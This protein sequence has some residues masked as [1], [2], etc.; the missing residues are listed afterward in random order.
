MRAMRMLDADPATAH[1]VV[2][3]KPPGP[4]SAKRIAGLVADMQT[5]VTL[6]ILGAGTSLT[7][8]AAAVAT[9]TGRTLAEPF[10]HVHDQAWRPA[11]LAGLFC[12]GSLSIEA[13]D[14]LSAWSEEI[15]SIASLSRTPTPEAI[16]S[17]DTHFL[18][19]LGDDRFTVGRPHP[20]IDPSIRRHLIKQ[21]AKRSQDRHLFL[22]VVLGR[23][24][25]ADPAGA[26]APSLAAF[27]GSHPHSSAVVSLVGSD[28]DSQNLL[29]QRDALIEVGCDVFASNAEAAE[30]VGRRLLPPAGSGN[31]RGS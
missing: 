24:A 15:G 4:Q 17:R 13:V 7:S 9:A 25:H 10:K 23:S 12:G 16:A 21:L 22:D 1:I 14:V 18:V 27:L 3:S 20:M 26:L 31:G 28:R 6:G 30:E 2:V 8:V 5:P 11:T 29:R 19:D